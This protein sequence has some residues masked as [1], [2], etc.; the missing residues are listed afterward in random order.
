MTT[1]R[2]MPTSKQI[3]DWWAKRLCR[4]RKYVSAGVSLDLF[5]AEWLC[6]ACLSPHQRND[7]QRAHI[8][9]RYLSGDDMPSNI[10]LL[11]EACHQASEFLTGRPY[12]NWF[13]RWNVWL[14]KISRL[15]ALE[16]A[17]ISPRGAFDYC[18]RLILADIKDGFPSMDGLRPIHQVTIDD[19]QE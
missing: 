3:K 4:S 17:K 16:A 9:P 10:H 7:L 2:R 8:E 11:C 6:F 15:P 13:V 18:S 19:W 5:R 1:K 12:W 14:N